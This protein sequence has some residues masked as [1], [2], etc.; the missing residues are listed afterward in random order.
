MNGKLI[1]YLN[2]TRNS[3]KDNIR[4]ILFSE[5]T[6]TYYYLFDINM[7]NKKCVMMCE[8]I[9]ASRPYCE[10]YSVYLEEIQY[11]IGPYQI[12]DGRSL[13]MPYKQVLKRL[14]KVE[15]RLLTMS[16]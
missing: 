3:K 6:F 7:E 15:E 9:N 8:L 16:Y 5:D 12:V 4:A 11:Y 2:K 14:K 10:L 1:K 13:G